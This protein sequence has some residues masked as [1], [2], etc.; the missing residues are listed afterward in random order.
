MKTFMIKK[1]TNKKVMKTR[2]SSPEEVIIL[3]RMSV[4]FM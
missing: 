1:L 2:T 3:D 4:Q